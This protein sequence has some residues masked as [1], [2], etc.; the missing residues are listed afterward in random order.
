MVLNKERIVRA[1]KRFQSRYKDYTGLYNSS[2]REEAINWFKQNDSRIL[3]GNILRTKIV[4]GLVKAS[5]SDIFIETGTSH[6]A[7]TIGVNR[8]LNIPVWSCE[9]SPSDFKISQFL[10][11]GLSNIQLFNLDSI[12][13]LEHITPILKKDKKI[14][15]FY[16]DAHEG[17]LDATSLPLAD[18]IRILKPL[19][20]FIVVI[21]DFK[22]PHDPEFVY[23][24]YGGISIDLGL[25]SNV[26]LELGINQC[27]LPAYKCKEETGFVTGFCIFWRSKQL[28]SKIDFNQFPFNLLKEYS[29]KSENNIVANA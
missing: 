27:F 6:A 12:K 24:T 23:G 16:L 18:E 22:I 13:F 3:N 19:D 1:I 5:G 29:V 10:T 20:E 2:S 14:P 26:L 4:Q 7:T 17:A 21:D 11:L 28:D 8:Y 15:I 9:N 25:I